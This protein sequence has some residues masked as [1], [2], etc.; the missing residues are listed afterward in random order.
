M[1]TFTKHLLTGLDGETWDIGRVGGALALVVGLGLQVYVVVWKGQPFD[2][3]AFGTGV[4]ALAIGI[5][6][7]L[8]L[9]ESTEPKPQ[10]PA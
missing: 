5:G 2:M 1:G 7:L 3:T 6:G 10:G 9:K 4:A 8:K